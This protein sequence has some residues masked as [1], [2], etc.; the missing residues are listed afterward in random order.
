[1]MKK[2]IA[3][4]VFYLPLQSIRGLNVKM[5]EKVVKKGENLTHDEILE[6]QNTKLQKIIRL[7]Y[8]NVPYYCNKSETIKSIARNYQNVSDLQNLPILTKR[9]ILANQ[10]DL[11]NPSFK[12]KTFERKTGGS[13]GLTL[14]FLKNAEALARNDAIMFR[15]YN[16][17]GIEMGDRQ[18]RF[19]GVPVDSGL[20]RQARIK[21]FLAN[22]ITISAFEISNASCLKQYHRIRKFKP[23][24]FYGYTTAIYGFCLFMKE[25]S[26]SLNDL[27]L[28][29][30]ICTAEKMYPHHR[31]L[32]HQVFNCPVVDEYGSSEN[33][34][35]AFQ[36]QKGNMHIM[37]DH[38]CVE[39]LGEDN[40]PVQTG[41]P[42]RIVVTDLAET[43]MPLIRY[44][45]GDIGT[46]SNQ[47]C[48]CGIQ[49]PIMEVL[50]GRKEDFIRKSNGDL[51]HAAYLCYTLK[52]DTIHEFKMYQKSL[53]Y[54]E[55]QIVKS[56]DFNDS[57]EMKIEKNLRSALGEDIKISFEYVKMIPREQSGKLR[58]FISEL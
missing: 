38:L 58:Y 31:R 15:C 56:P 2:F 4:N 16:W 18:V 33:G 5:Y 42:G 21:D 55:V 30:V 54:L 37:A 43:A 24:F 39:F 53:D 13:T 29:A 46:P 36:C 12:G 10:R 50:E 11:I 7:A 14:H 28:K 51:I 23:A 41:Q 25:N 9:E 8:N 48:S 22:R 40:I 3:K 47:T 35:I 20:R 26:I 44:E 49:L 52:E 57:S 19:W 34:I 45:I 32:F 27:N 17:Y 6:L 1:M